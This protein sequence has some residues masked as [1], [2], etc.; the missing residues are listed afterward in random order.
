MSRRFLVSGLLALAACGSE[1]SAD[2]DAASDAASDASIDASVCTDQ[3]PAG[4]ACSPIAS[5]ESGMLAPSRT[6]AKLVS[7]PVRCVLYALAD[8]QVLVFDTKAKVELPPIALPAAGVDIDVSH[9]GVR[10][11]VAHRSPRSVTEVDLAQRA[12][13]T[14]L[15]TV[16]EPGRLE[17]TASGT[18]FYT[19]F[20][21]FNSAH[22]LDL[23]TGADVQL[24]QNI[25]YQ[26]DIELSLDET[27]LFV[28][29]AGTSG[30]DMMAF[31]VSPDGLTQ[32]DQIHWN[33]RGGF[34]SATRRV[35]VT[36]AGNAYWAGHQWRADN[37]G[38]VTGAMLEDILAEDDSGTLAIGQ[39]FAWDVATGYKTEPLIGP[40]VAAAFA[41]G[42]QEAWMYAAGTL[43]YMAPADL[44]GPHP[45]GLRELPPAPL[46]EYELEQLVHDDARGTLYGRDSSRHAIIIID[47][48]T[49]QPTREIRVGPHPPIRSGTGVAASA[50]SDRTSHRRDR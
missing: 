46:G 17:V 41:G 39:L 40:V 43:R 3:A 14:T 21:Q 20:D 11:V 47:D 1:S 32:V 15:P 30:D 48:T 37:L 12:I 28:G 38:D 19:S 34:T 33:N 24:V 35:L 10:L 26:V 29:E 49:L 25:G 7:D 6:I 22:R 5:G 13:V 8:D 42:G 45:L 2:P 16:A 9:D 18:V 44:H 23:A 4:C 50:R 36:K 27:R 31:A